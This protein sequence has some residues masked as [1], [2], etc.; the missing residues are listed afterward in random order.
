M[1][2]DRF[3]VPS[4]LKMT[5]MVLSGIGLLALILGAVLILPKEHGAAR[6]W[7]ALLHNGVFFLLATVAS[8]FIMA[9]VSMAQGAWIIAYRRVTEAIGAN[10]WIFALILFI[11]LTCIVFGVGGENHIYHWLH[12]EGDEVLMSKSPFLNKGM[13][14]GFTIATLLGFSW[15]G[16]KFQKLSLDQE[17]AA[18]GSTK[19]YWK[20]ITIGAIFMVFYGLTTMSTAPWFWLMSIDAHWYSTMYSWYVFAS[21]FVTGMSLILLWTVYLKNQGNLFIVTKEHMH[22]LGKFMFA[23][24]IFW[25]Y[26]WFCQYM[27]IWYAN[28]PEETTYYMMRQ[29]GPYGWIFYASFILNFIFPILVLMSAPSKRNYFTIVFM[30]IIIILG[31]WMDFYLMVAPGPLGDNWHINWYEIGILLGFVGVMILTVSK[32]LSKSNLIPENNPMLKETI[33]HLS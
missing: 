9:A 22:D 5:G 31:H 24:S 18:K 6:F 4:K 11:V 16:K 20:T 10:V 21:S 1:I 12:P 3:E 32:T 17:K 7:V 28:I 23:F 27:L 15:F 25:T 8:I 30:A 13:F 29:H 14:F 26:T 33:V 2:T 19:I